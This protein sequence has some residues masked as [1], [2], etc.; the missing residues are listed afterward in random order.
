MI[1]ELIVR[2]TYTLRSGHKMKI[3]RYIPKR[4]ND[5]YSSD[6]YEIEVDGK[7]F[8]HTESFLKHL[9]YKEDYR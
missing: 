6:S 8:F 7:T 2:H 1:D 4:E 5:R 3:I 9:Q